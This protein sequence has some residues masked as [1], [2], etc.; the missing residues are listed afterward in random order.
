M[1]VKTF[2]T[3]AGYL[4]LALLMTFASAFVSHGDALAQKNET[5]ASELKPL[6]PVDTSSPRA[7]LSSFLSNVEEGYRPF[8]EYRNETHASELARNRAQRTLDT[9]GLAPALA[10]R[11]AGEATVLLKEILDRI[12]LPPESEIPD[13]E[14]MRELG[15]DT[16]RVWRIPDTALEIAEI[17]EG[18]RAGEYLFTTET[19][20]RAR[21]FY[22]RAQE[23][24]YK[25]DAM[26]GLYERRVHTPGPLIPSRLIF[27]LPY[28]TRQPL[29]QQ[30]IWQWLGLAVG[31]GIWAGALVAAHLVSRPR[32]NGTRR[33]WLRVTCVVA[34]LLLTL[35][36][37]NFIDMQL[38]IV[39]PTFEIVDTS[40]FVAF[41]LLAA[42]GVIN[43][44]A[45]VGE[46]I[47][48]SPRI[49]PKSIDAHLIRVSVRAVALAGVIAILVVAADRLGIPLTAVI[50]SLGVGGFAFA[51]AVRPTLE[52]F[53]AGIT[54]FLDKPVRVG[55][56]CQ[57]GD[58]IG[59]V[60]EIGLRSTR[61]R[62]WGGNLLAVP[63]AQFA[64]FQI[65]NYDDARHIWIRTQID[66]RYETTADQ[67]R[68]VLARMREMLMAHPKLSGEPRVRLIG[69]GDFSLKVEILA[70]TDTGTWS[71]WH[72][73][74]EDVYLRVMEV[75]EEAGTAFAFPSNTTYFAR[76]PGLDEGK[77]RAAEA[78]VE[79]WR[80]GGHLP[81]PNMSIK[82]RKE[83]RGTLDFPP[84]GSVDLKDDGPKSG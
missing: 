17:T 29:G 66:L 52:N 57:F 44:G 42:V 26:V 48:T 16:P 38:T 8:Y 33:Y 72:A 19:V 46:T 15:E 24:P 68:Y 6:A 18:P 37:R 77:Q 32:P 9:S 84:K 70:Y 76:D 27:A 49:D 65:D 67:M 11:T 75:V 60:E 3:L 12:P 7:T 50:A 30:A 47:I 58:V 53:F 64:E 20:T 31:F 36:F 28:W 55:E 4:R 34:M 78:Q 83:I 14:A 13:A 71:E 73:I 43:L 21:E 74:R 40:L 81:F 2:H 79:T 23:L 25:S 80:E 51:L 10:D 69:F 63:N 1:I 54:L 61:I 5:N 41:F 82:R 62:R 39:G 35:A 22:R 45:A 59:T 56:F